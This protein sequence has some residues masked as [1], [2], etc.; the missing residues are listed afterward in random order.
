MVA[1]KVLKIP[2]NP[3]MLNIDEFMELGEKRKFEVILTAIANVNWTLE[4][5]GKDLYELKGKLLP[6]TQIDIDPIRAKH[7]AE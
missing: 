7:D 2:E 4:A 3:Y 5:M 1:G 6:N